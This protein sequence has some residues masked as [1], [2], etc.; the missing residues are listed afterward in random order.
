MSDSD[1]R[2]PCQKLFS[3][4]TYENA[5]MTYQPL[6]SRRVIF[7]TLRIYDPFLELCKKVLSVACAERNVL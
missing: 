3:V 4:K 7:T 6:T 5:E 2:L 1:T